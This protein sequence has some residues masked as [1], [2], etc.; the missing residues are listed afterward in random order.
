MSEQRRLRVGVIFGGRNSEHEVS[1]K[2]ARSVMDALDTALYDIMPIGIDKDGRWL[3]GGD[4]L[5]ALEQAADPR[6]LGHQP[7]AG[8]VVSN[9]ALQRTPGRL[10]PSAPAQLDVILPVL[11]GLYGEDGTLQGLLELAG[12]PYAGCGVLASSVAMDKGVARAAFAA[13]GLPQLPYLLLRRSDWQANPENAVS[14]IERAL[15]YPVFTKPANAGS[16]VGVSKCRNRTELL[17][18]LDLAAL[19]DRRLIVERGINA[20]EIEVAV[21]GNDQPA[22]S[23]PGE[24]VPAHEWYDYA[25]KYL[26]GNTGYLIPAPLDAATARYIQSLAVAAFRAIDGAGLARVDF[27][28]DRSSGALYLNE[29]NTLPGF[30]SGSMYPKLWAASGLPYSRLLDRFIELALERH[31]DQRVREPEARSRTVGDGE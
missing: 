21:L 25:D 22:A 23:V 29:V 6:L 10:P 13:A 24:I 2:S 31:A 11:H 26:D 27:L 5:L 17:A 12:V 8:V 20:R 9:T 3:V 15:P 28:M 18:G 7:A 19:N 1:L 30:T 14:E 4:P 16:S